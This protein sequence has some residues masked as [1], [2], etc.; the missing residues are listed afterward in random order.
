MSGEVGVLALFACRGCREGS[1]CVGSLRPVWRLSVCI[2][3]WIAIAVAGG[4]VGVLGSVWSIC[5]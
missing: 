5:S 2:R 3:L 4:V 1:A